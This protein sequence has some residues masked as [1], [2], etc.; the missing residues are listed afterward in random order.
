MA[1]LLPCRKFHE[2]H[3]F[4][5]GPFF[6]FPNTSLYIGINLELL[7]LLLWCR[8]RRCQI[9]TIHSAR[10]L[11]PSPLSR[12]NIP[13]HCRR[14]LDCRVLTFFSLTAPCLLRLLPLK[15]TARA[16]RI[17]G[18]HRLRLL[19]DKS[20]PLQLPRTA[21]RLRTDNQHPPRPLPM[22]QHRT[23]KRMAR[24]E[25]LLRTI[26]RLLLRTILQHPHPM[27]CTASLIN[28]GNN[29][30]SNRPKPLGHLHQQATR[31][32]IPLI[33]Q[34]LKRPASASLHLLDTLCRHRTMDLHK[35]TSR[36]L[37]RHQNL[38]Y[39]LHRNQLPLRR[40]RHSCR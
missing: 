1:P 24:S 23:A 31:I 11:R 18:V 15:Q 14:R 25:D 32:R 6:A 8:I 20:H 28:T 22:G 27:V 38:R 12:K 2:C 34:E 37:S 10:R 35:I 30:L 3:I 33:H 16:I 4:G 29:L 36:G 40:I 17:F 13:S 39:M 9:Q 7:L 26:S 21:L 19:T 5:L